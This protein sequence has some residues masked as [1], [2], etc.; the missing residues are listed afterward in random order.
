LTNA[1][2]TD[3][4]LA[5]LSEN[6]RLRRAARAHSADMLD[7]GYFAHVAQWRRVRRS[8]PRFARYIRY[9]N[10]WSVGENLAWGTGTHATA[11]SVHHAWMG[12]SGHRSNILKPAYRE[13]GI[14]VRVG[15]P[16]E[17]GIG[18]TYTIEFGV[19]R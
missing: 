4:G 14:G 1:A 19:S 7:G 6:P 11:R 18:A 5:A 9:G 16:R 2:R 8:H 13:L 15:T 12:S 17:A 3:R 10:R